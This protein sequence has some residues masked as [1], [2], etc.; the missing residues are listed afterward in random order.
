MNAQGVSHAA[1]RLA[2]ILLASSAWLAP[3]TAAIASPASENVPVPGGLAA[4]AQALD[5]TAP[6]PARCLAE[7]ARLVH[8]DNAHARAREDSLFRR[9]LAHFA[10]VSG[11]RSLPH[12]T[13]IVPVPLNASVWSHAVFGKAVSPQTLFAEILS[14]PNAAL[15]A[16]GL[17]ALDDETLT[18]FQNHPTLVTT[19]YQ[20]H[21]I[22]FASFPSH[23][24]IRN[25]RVVTPGGR[26]ATALWES[27]LAQRSIDPAA[28][29]TALY[30][31]SHG[32]IAYL[33]DVIG[34]LDE[35]QAAFALGSWLNDQTARVDRFRALARLA[36]TMVSE[37]EADRVPF[38][39]PA[40]D[41]LALLQ[42]VRV[43]RAGVPQFPAARGLWTAALSGNPGDLRSQPEGARLA[44]AAWLAGA[45]LDGHGEARSTRLDQLA[46]GQRVFS[47]ARDVPES[48][49]VR[50]IHD[51]RRTPTLMLMA[52][53]IGVTAPRI[54]AA[55]GAHA[56]RIAALNAFAEQTALAQFQGALVL[57]ERLVRVRSIDRASAVRCV[58]TLAAVPLDDERGYLGGLA[59][60]LTDEIGAAIA[61]AAD[62]PFEEAL[63]SALAGPS[64]RTRVLSWEG[65]TYAFDVA[66]TERMRLRRF[67]EQRTA[68]SL[69]LAIALQ[70]MATMP[71]E[72]GRRDD[73]LARLRA[74]LAILPHG[75]QLLL[76]LDRAVPAHRADL[77]RQAADAIAADALVSFAYA[78]HWPDP[79]GSSRL[80]REMPRR[81]DFGV[82]SPSRQVRSRRAWSVARAAF[83]PG[84]PVRVE[85]SLLGLEMAL[86]SLALRRTAAAPAGREPRLLST[87]R[88][89]FVSSLG[90]LDTFALRD[91]DAALIAAAI[92]RGQRRVDALTPDSADVEA[93]IREVSLDGWRARA[94]RWDLA[95]ARNETPGLFS[96]TEL[97][98]LGDG[99]DLDVHAW[100]MSALAADACLCTQLPRPGLQTAVVGR[101]HLGLLPAT[102]PDLNLRVAVVLH[103]LQLPAALA[104]KVLD[105]ALYDLLT[106]VSPTHF[107]D[108]L[109][110]VRRARAVSRERIED[111]LA[112]V[113][114]AAGPLVLQQAERRTQ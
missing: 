61:P 107:D 5:I 69:D 16:H 41:L 96:L 42:R 98:Y 78:I 56:D 10:A 15:I 65:Q 23:L 82:T 72:G 83:A 103:E 29:V 40:F 101:H 93:V 106:D 25:G 38:T 105:A 7:I 2:T 54:Y 47:T 44:D 52:E 104:R 57:I 11:A 49:L 48:E 60:W 95:Y 97:L 21:A 4:L 109:T 74:S 46:F 20:R 33:Y 8:A 35:D 62:A 50:A 26:A 94:L 9:L 12:Q 43:D 92:A 39:R 31:S 113:T 71:Q 36:T 111:Y 45:A 112:G 86:A 88:H 89:A 37:W 99:R 28:F 32:R 81:H 1:K 58:E 55:L 76:Q 91:S 108:W 70:R 80:E 13:E 100:G 6:D 3:A 77:W 27:V 14:N 114:A 51:F 19:L 63:I 87:N 30:G 68:T 34:H 59:A 85:G 102:I 53:R 67:R 90:L 17:S 110:I 75:Q 73:T 24:R 66:A 22:V 79:T 64:S 18:F 84:E